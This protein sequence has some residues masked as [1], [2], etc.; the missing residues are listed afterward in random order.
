MDELNTGKKIKFDF[1]MMRTHCGLALGNGAFG[2]LLWGKE[3]NILNLTVSRN[4][5]WDRQFQKSLSERISYAETI[6]IAEETGDHQKIRASLNAKPI[7]ESECPSSLI[8]GGRFDFKLK[9]GLTL[10]AAELNCANGELKVFL[11]DSDYCLT[12]Q[13][14]TSYDFLLIEDPDSVLDEVI[15]RPAWEWIQA[16]LQR[17]G[18]EKPE[19]LEGE[20]KGWIQNT[21]VDE[22]LCA[23]CGRIEN[24]Y[25][26]ALSLGQN[27]ED[28]L[29]NA[30]KQIAD[31]QGQ[32]SA[33]FYEEN[34]AWWKNYWKNVPEI[35]IPCGFFSQ[36]MDYAQYKFACV[37]NPSAPK[38][39]PLQGPW[40]EEYRMP[41]WGGDY[42][43]NINV[44][45]IYYLTFYGGNL[46]HLNPLFDMMESP[47]FQDI[48]HQNAKNLLGID[49]GLLLTHSVN[50]R[51]G[52]CQLGFS[53]HSTFDHMLGAWMV[54]LYW[55][56][57]QHTLDK[58]FLKE[59]AFPLMKGII[60]VFEAML[61]ERN[62]YLSLPLSVSPEYGVSNFEG[63][64]SGRDS[65]AQFAAIHMLL[66]ALLETCS[67]LDELPDEFW[68]EMKKK[69]PLYTVFPSKRGKERIAIWE[70]QDLAVSHRHH[71]HL[72]CIYP[73]DCLGKMTA[74]KETIV[75]NSINH[76]L[77][78]GM[79]L[80]SEW[81]FPWAAI[82]EARLGMKE[83]PLILLNI[84]KEV[85]LNEGLA[86]VYIPRFEG[87]TAHREEDITK[88]KEGLEFIQVD[89]TM[90][91]A[92]AIYEM[93]VHTHSGVT[94]IFPA[95]PAKWRN[96]SFR[97]I[98]QPGP[99]SI[100]AIKENSQIKEI[101]IKSLG[102]E[103]INLD[104]GGE[105]E[106]SMDRSGQA[107]QIT[108]PA[109]LKLQKGEELVLSR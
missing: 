63:R 2:A 11:K 82:I 47:D 12:L 8:P 21:P 81:C 69:V 44:E 89:G 10:D 99:F 7:D 51:G 77:Y 104:V 45:Q 107:S 27:A 33:D 57:Y 70:G 6:R 61:E 39:C 76:W 105:K 108:L 74:E 24:G 101:R 22:S 95:T 79:G 20:A 48:M 34:S 102:G 78:K 58:D 90:G 92:T 71:S 53:P 31:F 30:R 37:T 18:C 84:W 109:V 32:S 26:I 85:F 3:K 43:V 80:W 106:F 49:D 17:R 29:S 98:R 1:P 83:G 97:G 35:S 65:S 86:S 9:D 41:S 28:A 94:R 4:D 64:Q 55:L 13:M 91:S 73:F 67:I 23:Y 100:S 36:F 87:F 60:R 96:V 56:Y 25:G 93:L 15:S 54:Q 46:D 66:D 72:A 103:Q 16:D 59:R 5:F 40:L 52:Q 38:P 42:T 68:L 88:P 50:D 75:K 62:G 19:N 14:S